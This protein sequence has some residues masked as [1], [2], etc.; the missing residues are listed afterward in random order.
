M[1][2]KIIRSWIEASQ[3]LLADKKAKPGL[4]LEGCVFI[5]N[6]EVRQTTGRPYLLRSPTVHF[7]TGSTPDEVELKIGQFLL[8]ED[9]RLLADGIEANDQDTLPRRVDDPPEDVLEGTADIYAD[10]PL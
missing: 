1:K 9:V 4:P 8:R 3:G 7:V 2:P 10:K 6:C 5:N